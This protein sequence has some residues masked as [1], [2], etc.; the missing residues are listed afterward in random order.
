MRVKLVKSITEF[1]YLAYVD[2]FCRMVK[3]KARDSLSKMPPETRMPATPFSSILPYIS[4][5]CF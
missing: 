2:N 4:S 5:C 1:A 3:Q